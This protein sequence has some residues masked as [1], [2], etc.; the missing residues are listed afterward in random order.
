MM[1]MMIMMMIIII[2]KM[3][4][5]IH[6]FLMHVR[7]QYLQ[8][9]LYSVPITYVMQTLAHY[10]HFTCFLTRNMWSICGTGWAAGWY[11]RTETM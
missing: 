5:I 8:I 9:I 3:I 7:S 6:S 1:V 4:I 2:I 11:C 10:S